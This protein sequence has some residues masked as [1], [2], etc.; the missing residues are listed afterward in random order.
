MTEAKLTRNLL[1]IVGH[2]LGGSVIFKH[3]DRFTSGI[4]DSSI[5]WNSKTIWLEIKHANPKIKDT[6]IQEHTMLR[7]NLASPGLAWYVVYFQDGK[8]NEQKTFLL[9]PEVIHNREMWSSYPWCN[10]FSHTFVANKLMELM[11]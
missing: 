2:E 4:P 7:L 3:A 9:P 1:L 11:R 5:I 6:G 10:G 8:Q